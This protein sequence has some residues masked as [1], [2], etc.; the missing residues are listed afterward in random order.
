MFWI[1]RRYRK[2]QTIYT[3]YGEAKE[4]FQKGWEAIRDPYTS[5]DNSACYRGIYVS[6][7]MTNPRDA[8]GICHGDNSS[9]AGCV[10]TESAV[11]EPIPDGAMFLDDCAI[12]GGHNLAVDDCGICFEVSDRPL[13]RSGV[14]GASLP[15]WT[16]RASME[17]PR[18]GKGR[19]LGVSQS[20]TFSKAG[21]ACT[22]A[23]RSVHIS[24]W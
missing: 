22:G 15:P 20:P 2:D 8:C 14:R 5:D 11:S 16:C 10:T 4:Y 17:K 23:G 6:G 18:K 9:C 12:C 7:N 3:T 19:R 24:T 21:A 1:C 13:L